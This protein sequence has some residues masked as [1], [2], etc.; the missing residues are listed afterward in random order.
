MCHLRRVYLAPLTESRLYPW[1]SSTFRPYCL[2][3]KL[4]ERLLF[5]LFLFLSL[6]GARCT[7]P[8]VPGPWLR[9][10]GSDESP[11]QHSC[12]DGFVPSRRHKAR[13][14]H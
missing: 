14:L 5:C 12:V 8:A 4:V 7:L 2:S 1:A 10:R 3:L 11:S 13:V 6:H 9:T